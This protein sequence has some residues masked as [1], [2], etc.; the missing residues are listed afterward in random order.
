MTH[1]KRSAIAGVVLTASLLTLS[2]PQAL[3][4]DAGV[5]TISE[6]DVMPFM[7]YINDADSQFSIS[8]GTASVN[9]WVRGHTN[10]TTKCKVVVKLQVKSGTG[11]ATVKTWT[12]EQN[13]Q[14]A[15]VNETLSVSS[16][17][18]YRAVTTVTAWSGSKSESKTITSDTVKA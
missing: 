1:G 10:V 13:G 14:R 9:A 3:A 17:K 5:M 8:K 6:E 11:W 15:S 16:G 12:S 2:L 18:S 4:L 7:T